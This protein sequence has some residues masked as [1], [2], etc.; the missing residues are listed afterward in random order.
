[1]RFPLLSAALCLALLQ[2]H[3]LAQDSPIA[4]KPTI[5]ISFDSGTLER[6][7][8]PDRHQRGNMAI[9]HDSRYFIGRLD[10]RK[11]V[12]LTNARAELVS[13][14]HNIAYAL[15]SKDSQRVALFGD[16]NDDRKTVTV[17]NLKT[18]EVVSTIRTQEK[19]DQVSISPDGERIATGRDEVKLIRK[20]TNVVNLWDANNGTHIATI[21]GC[22]NSTDMPIFSPDSRSLLLDCEK[23]KY[24]PTKI[25]DA[26]TGTEIASLWQQAK[27]GKYEF[28][29]SS[30]PESVFSPDGSTIVSIYRF[31]GIRI[32]DVDSRKLR[33]E[34]VASQGDVHDITFTKDGRWF[35]TNGYSPV[36]R[37]WDTLTGEK[38]RV[39]ETDA[40]KSPSFFLRA[41][42]SNSGG[43]LAGIDKRGGV[44]VWDTK[45][46]G[47]KFVLNGTAK[48]EDFSV[49]AFFGQDDRVLF[50]RREKELMLF[51]TETGKEI[52]SIPN[53]S[54]AYHLSPDGTKLFVLNSNH[55][56]SI[57]E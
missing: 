41:V 11:L 16:V 26:R 39:F 5:A 42:F 4:M 44:T 33:K 46:A 17:L 34:F 1:M 20:G 53:P 35:A 18:G 7:Y 37:M 36:I 50:V 38:Y 49:N 32:W 31:N 56:I 52:Q 51:D 43:M 57:W 45:N 48:K 14:D 40:T 22:A 19:I 47:V 8:N 9:S 54:S 13:V 24:K 28:T 27:Q 30:A 29:P 23:I 10:K 3:N 25:F 15:F 12:V 55:S 6:I 21:D 2:T